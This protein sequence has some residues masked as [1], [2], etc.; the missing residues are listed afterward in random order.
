MSG[1]RSRYRPGRGRRPVCRAHR[2]LGARRVGAGQHW[3][4][5][6]SPPVRSSPPSGPTAPTPACRT[7]A[8]MPRSTSDRTTRTSRSWTSGRDTRPAPR[9][10]HG[11]ARRAFRSAA[12]ATT[13]S[14]RIDLVTLGLLV[15]IGSHAAWAD[16]VCPGPGM[17]LFQ[18]DQKD[19]IA[20]I[21][22]APLTSGGYINDWP[23]RSWIGLT[24]VGLYDHGVSVA[25]RLPAGLQECRVDHTATK[26]TALCW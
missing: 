21:P 17:S 7:A 26:T 15:G 16:S 14:C 1:S 3:A 13:L 20:L 11:T 23:L 22:A 10:F 19:N 24:A 5:P 25:L 8:P 9:R 18:G 6:H 4:T 12:G 2:H